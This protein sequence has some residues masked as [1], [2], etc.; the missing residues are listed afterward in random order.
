MNE[1]SIAAM[2][3]ISELSVP[4]LGSESDFRALNPVRGVEKGGPGGLDPLTFGQGREKG[5]G[6]TLF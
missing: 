5:V 4:P 3:F 6:P 2:S 1:S